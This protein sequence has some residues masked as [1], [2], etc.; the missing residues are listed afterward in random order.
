MTKSHLLATAVV[1]IVLAVRAGPIAQ[2]RQDNDK[3]AADAVKN[4]ALPLI[5]SRTMSFTTSE[6]TW[7]SLDLSRDGRT[8]VFELLGDLY[9]LP[10]TGGKPRA[11]RAAGVRH[12]ARVLA[13]RQAHRLRQRS[14]RIRKRVDRQQRWHEAA[15]VT[16]TERENYMSP[17]WTPDG[18]Y[19]IAAKGAQLWMYHQDGGSGVQMTG[20]RA[21][22]GG[23]RR[24]AAPALLGPSSQGSAISVGERPR[25][26]SARLRRAQTRN[27]IPLANY[28]PHREIRSSAR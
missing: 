3:A 15:A 11:S 16:T 1:A 25:Q 17:I 4:R 21:P 7:L 23:R 10:I 9:T 24:T 28:D 2:T 6:G 18:E 5:T 26:R 27:R 20:A 12:A 22:A 13:G 8:I 19:V 14:Q